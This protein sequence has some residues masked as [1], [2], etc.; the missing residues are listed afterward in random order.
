MILWSD[1]VPNNPTQYCIVDAHASE[2]QLT[3]CGK[4]PPPVQGRQPSTTP[5]GFVEHWIHYRS[6]GNWSVSQTTKFWGNQVNCSS[7]PLHFVTFS[8][9]VMLLLFLLL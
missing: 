8:P 5:C 1:P 9:S 2:T 6:V 4:T 7:E 3:A